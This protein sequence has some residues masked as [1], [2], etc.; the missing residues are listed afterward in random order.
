VRSS[1]EGLKEGKTAKKCEYERVS[2]ALFQLFI[3]QREKGM[4]V[5]G[6]LVQEK[7]MVFRKE[8]D[9]GEC[10]F[11]AAIGWVD[12]WKKRNGLRQPN[13]WGE[14]LSAASE[15]LLKFGEWC[16]SLTQSEG[17]SYEPA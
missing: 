17:L 9:A 3:H 5:T 13:I 4:L 8:F 15:S 6:P 14:D 2:E 11:T 1:T 7:V 12:H 10:D 16:Q